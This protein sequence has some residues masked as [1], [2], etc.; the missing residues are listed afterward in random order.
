MPTFR[1]VDLLESWRVGELAG[2][3]AMWWKEAASVRGGVGG[4][5]QGGG[6]SSVTGTGERSRRWGQTVYPRVRREGTRRRVQSGGCRG[7][8]VLKRAG[9]GCEKERK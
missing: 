4:W 9:G 6:F 5:I 8:V 2:A 1:L 7:L 3:G